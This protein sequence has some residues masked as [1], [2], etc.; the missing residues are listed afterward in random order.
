MNE[1]SCWMERTSSLILCYPHSPAKVT[2]MYTICAKAVMHTLDYTYIEF[3]VII[4]KTFHNIT[5]PVAIQ[6]IYKIQ[7]VLIAEIVTKFVL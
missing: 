7:T 1:K 3:F 4:I 6:N 2:I 5:I